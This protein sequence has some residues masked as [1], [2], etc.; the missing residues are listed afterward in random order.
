MT[1]NKKN[2]I[3][4]LLIKWKY[5]VPYASLQQAFLENYKINKQINPPFDLST[6]NPLIE[7]EIIKDK[8]I[9]S[10]PNCMWLKEQCIIPNSIPDDD[11]SEI[12]SRYNYMCIEKIKRKIK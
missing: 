7:I 10:V 2:F 3:K 6:V 8:I 5:L 4:F 11:I 9:K 12:Y 1:S